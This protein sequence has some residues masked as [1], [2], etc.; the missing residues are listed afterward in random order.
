M[1]NNK[2]NGFWKLKFCKNVFIFQNAVKPLFKIIQNYG[3]SIRP[4]FWWCAECGFTENK[5]IIV[6][7]LVL[8]S[9]FWGYVQKGNALTQRCVHE[10]QSSH[11][12]ST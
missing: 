5:E 6:D 10:P 8:N 2:N 9:R 4:Q 3:E 7:K 1:N 11:I 12:T